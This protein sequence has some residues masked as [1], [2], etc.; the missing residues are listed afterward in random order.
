MNAPAPSSPPE[1]EIVIKAS[2][3]W[4][5]IDWRG[6]LAYR[7]L[8]RQLIQRDFT[9][10]YKQT[11]LGPTWFFLNPIV[12]TLTFTLVFNKVI[13]VPTDGVPPILFYLCGMLGWS[14]FATV[15]GNTGNSFGTHC[16]F[17]VIQN[18]TQ[19]DP[20]PYFSGYELEPGA[21]SGSRQRCRE[22]IEP[23]RAG[24]SGCR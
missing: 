9:A 13:G 1:T 14:Y 24:L 11:I 7:D 4:F 12:T 5:T 8:L 16:H 17:E 15:L 10:R 20:L 18:G 6:L 19:I 21:A 2:S 23:P 22:T 3:A